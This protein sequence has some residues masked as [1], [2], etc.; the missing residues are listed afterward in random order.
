MDAKYSEWGN[1]I[2]NYYSTKHT[3]T[4]EFEYSDNWVEWWQ[5][6]KK[7]H[8]IL[9]FVEYSDVSNESIIYQ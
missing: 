2:M 4:V 1:I 7:S 6:R 5:K 9:K 8:E 3:G